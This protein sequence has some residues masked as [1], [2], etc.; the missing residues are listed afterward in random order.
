MNPIGKTLEK[1]KYVHPIGVTVTVD[2]S[3]NI[4]MSPV[5]RTNSPRFR[6]GERCSLNSTAKIIKYISS[7]GAAQLR[8][9]TD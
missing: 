8:R 9:S 2:H 6:L 5:Y 4:S 3:R 1:S 7:D